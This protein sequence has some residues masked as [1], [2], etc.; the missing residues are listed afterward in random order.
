MS[1]KRG[2][3]QRAA[4]KYFFQRETASRFVLGYLFTFRENITDPLGHF[5]R[6]LS[7]APRKVRAIE[8]QGHGG[9]GA[10]SEV[11]PPG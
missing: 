10:K 6:K 9:G 1:W 8:R 4:L 2:G 11:P 5:N 7:R 3:V